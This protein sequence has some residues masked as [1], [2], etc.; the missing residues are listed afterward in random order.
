V[1]Q[2]DRQLE[3]SVVAV[4]GAARGIGL[5]TAV[6]LAEHGARVA[7]GDIDAAL[8]RDVAEPLGDNAV[9]LPLDVT[10]RASFAAFL[11]EAERRLG[12]I[13]A[14]I[15]NAGIMPLGSFISESDETAT[16]QLNINV[17]GVILGMKLVLPGM[18]ERGRGHIVNIASAAGK[19]GLPGGVTY[20]ATKHAVVGLTEAARAELRG[21]GVELSLVMPTVVNTEL[22]SGLPPTRGLRFVEPE[23]VAASIVDALIHRRFEVFVPRSLGA[24]GKV[25]QLLPR[26]GRDAIT[27][28][29]GADQVLAQPDAARRA[30]YERRLAATG[31]ERPFRPV[32]GDDEHAH[33]ERSL[34]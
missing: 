31:G 10:D 14:L 29:L 32:E 23:E 26:R 22:G 18:L 13:D 8:A 12:A 34:T 1:R 3:D 20:C 27:R 33:H 4:T 2:A 17:H 11:A 24:I 9:G 5:A 16:R 7:I 6:A 19:T 25:T 15:N 30:G 28:V 21:T